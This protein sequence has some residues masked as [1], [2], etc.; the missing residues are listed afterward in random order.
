MNKDGN[1][2]NKTIDQNVISS[3]KLSFEMLVVLV[4]G[5][6]LDSVGL[7]LDSVGLDMDSSAELRLDALEF[8]LGSLIERTVIL[9]IPEPNLLLRTWRR[10][11]VIRM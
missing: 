2:T 7:D 6:E 11:F 3:R 4:L 5:L 8:D 9:L 1:H 10:L